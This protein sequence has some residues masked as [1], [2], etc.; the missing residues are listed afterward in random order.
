VK[1][2]MLLVQ[3]FVDLV[4]KA[5]ERRDLRLVMVG[6]GALRAELQHALAA[7]NAADLAWLPGERNDIADILKGIDIFVMPSLNEGISNTIL[8][9]MATGLPVVATNVG[10]NPEL[11]SPGR[12]GL[13]VEPGNPAALADGIRNYLEQP[14]MMAEHG[15]MARREVEENFSLKS[16]VRQ[17][18]DVYDAVTGIAGPGRGC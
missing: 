11:V 1:N 13:L 18:L 2:P 3:A 9:A 7:A 12:T 15:N 16:M 4:G 6:D 14:D 10:G 17:Y 8:E 5:G